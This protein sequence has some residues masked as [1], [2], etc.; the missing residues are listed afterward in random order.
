LTCR[1]IEENKEEFGVEPICRTLA[2]AGVKIAPSTYYARKD[3]PASRRAVRD[4]GL[5]KEIHQV[6]EKNYSVFG[7]RKM[8][9]VL[10]WADPNNRGHVA[11][12]TVERLMRREGLSGIRWATP[13]IRLTGRKASRYLLTFSERQCPGPAPLGRLI[14]ATERQQDRE[15]R[16]RR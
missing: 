14:E 11:R 9:A 12:C 16:P 13:P 4:E 7:A 6:H 1:Y 2:E 3:R 8:H 10:N 15:D 5:V